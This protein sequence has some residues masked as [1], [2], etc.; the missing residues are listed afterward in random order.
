MKVKSF[1]GETVAAALKAVRS[2]LGGNAVIL[3]TR[4]LPHAQRTSAGNRIEVTACVDQAESKRAIPRPEMLGE[5]ETTA[6]IPS[7]TKYGEIPINNLVNKLDFLIDVFQTPLRK[8]AFPGNI[9][10]LFA[11]LLHADIPE[12]MAYELCE[13]LSARFKAEGE[14]LPLSMAALEQLNGQLPKLRDNVG[15]PEGQKLVLVGPAGAG[16]SLLVARLAG[17]L[18]NELKRGVCLT[19]LDNVKVA[20]P[21]EIQSYADILDVE[22]YDMPREN[23]RTSL[24]HLNHET[25]KIIDT[26][27]LNTR[28]REDI[29]IYAEKLA[30]IKP[31]RII[32]VFP[33]TLRTSDM[34]DM[35]R[36]FRPLKITE[37]AITM[38][39]QTCRLGGATAVSI[40]TGLPITIL[41]N[42]RKTGCINLDPDME[43]LIKSF[44]GIEEDDNHE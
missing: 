38:T 15:F 23:E 1:Y 25:I 18:I 7:G 19:S 32:G 37:L 28:D 4:K 6:V 26:P 20:A 31:D 14:Y 42:G 10:R 3:K 27:A 12:S 29:E 41:G 33:A 2:E 8:S 35:I 22:F 9:G 40:Q 21:E 17:Y 43:S 30:R 5:S 44:L 13:N 24:D 16:K 36:A 11:T 39:D 34:F